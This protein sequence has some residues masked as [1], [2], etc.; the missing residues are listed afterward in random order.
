METLDLNIK[1]RI[2]V[3]YQTGLATNVA[4]KA[5]LVLTLGISHANEEGRVLLELYEFFSSSA[6][7]IHLGPMASVMSFE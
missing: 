5:N 1:D 6:S 7:S 2:G 4:G 3:D